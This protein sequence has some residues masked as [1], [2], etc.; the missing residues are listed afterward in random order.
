MIMSCMWLTSKPFLYTRDEQPEISNHALHILHCM[1]KNIQQAEA[2]VWCFIQLMRQRELRPHIDTYA[3]GH[4]PVKAASAAC[5]KTLRLR[6]KTLEHKQ[7]QCQQVKV[8]FLLCTFCLGL[9]VGRR[10]SVQAVTHRQGSADW[11][12]RGDR[13]LLPLDAEVRPRTVGSDSKFL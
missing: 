10:S 4:M 1:R 6:H 8:C 5:C 3:L 12:P 9:M 11:Q 7:R 13:R 2:E